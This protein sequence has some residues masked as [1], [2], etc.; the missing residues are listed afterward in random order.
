MMNFEEPSVEV[1][2][3]ATEE[4]MSNPDGNMGAE[5]GNMD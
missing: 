1:S 3:L 5:S 2:V 4:T